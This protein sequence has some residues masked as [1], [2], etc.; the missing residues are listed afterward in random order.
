MVR[1]GADFLNNGG[2]EAGKVAG[3]EGVAGL[4]YVYKVMGDTSAFGRGRLGS[5]NIKISINL[6]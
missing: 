6:E 1:P 2:G 4:R 5:S 3:G